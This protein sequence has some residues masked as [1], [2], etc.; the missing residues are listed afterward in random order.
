[1]SSSI[2]LLL[3]WIGRR[4]V[5]AP[6]QAKPDFSRVHDTLPCK[7]FSGPAMGRIFSH[8]LGVPCD[9]PGMA[10]GAI[11]VDGQAGIVYAKECGTHSTF[12]DRARV[13]SEEL[14]SC[15]FAPSL[16]HHTAE[17]DEQAVTRRLD[18]PAVMRGDLRNRLQR[19]EM[20]VKGDD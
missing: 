6:Q 8:A 19:H 20:G 5:A 3:S 10:V 7:I 14:S 11:A 16:L 9:G 18:E 2:H 15:R 13:F 12:E 1:V 4:H 17:L